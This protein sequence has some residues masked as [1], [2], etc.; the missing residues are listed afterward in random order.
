MTEIDTLHS[1][2]MRRHSCRAFLDKPVPKADIEKII[3]VAGRV[4]SWCNAQPWQVMV[5]TPD[6]TETFREALM[7]HVTG[8]GAAQP[9]LPF[10]SGYSGAHQERRRECGFQLY[11]AVG[12]E[13]G[14]RA[15]SARQMMENFN[16]FGAPH[17][18]ILTSGA[19]LGPY[20][21]MD[22]GGFVTAFTLAAEA[23]GIAS[24]PQAAVASYAP[25]VKEYFE[26]GSDRLLLCAISFG[27]RDED[28]PANS[29]RTTRAELGDILKWKGRP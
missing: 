15:A 19:E 17:V 25:F 27:Y 4:P 6:E 29:F 11:D 13:K 22:A 7:A 8:G 21:A 23:L 12:I 18:A 9:D 16:L 3:E 26:I 1:L 20:G 2:L 28:H 10:P 14:D 5:T 24:I